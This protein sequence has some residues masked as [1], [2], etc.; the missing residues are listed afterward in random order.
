MDE[1]HAGLDQDV[2]L[3][4]E[5]GD[6]QV[7]I[8]ARNARGSY[9]VPENQVDTVADLLDPRKIWHV[10]DPTTDNKN[11]MCASGIEK[12]RCHHVF[13][14]EDIRKVRAHWISI[15]NP[16]HHW[17][18]Y[19]QDS[20]T[21]ERSPPNAQKVPLYSVAGFPWRETPIEQQ[22]LHYFLPQGNGRQRVCRRFFEKG[23]GISHYVGNAIAAGTKSQDYVRPLRHKLPSYQHKP[24]Q[25]AECISF[26]EIFFGDYAQT[27]GDGHRYFPVS[28]SF[29]Y[30]YFNSFWPWW[31]ETHGE[32]EDKAPAMVPEADQELFEATQVVKP[33]AMHSPEEFRNYYLGSEEKVEEEI[34]DDN[35]PLSARNRRYHPCLSMSPPLAPMSPPQSRRGSSSSPG[36]LPPS[37]FRLPLPPGSPEDSLDSDEKEFD[38]W[39]ADQSESDAEDEAADTRAAMRDLKILQKEKGFPSFSTFLRAR[40]NAR[41]DNVKKRAKHFHCKCNTCDTLQVLLYRALKNH[42]DRSEY[43]KQRK[44]H[45]YEVKHWREKEVE[46]HRKAKTIPGQVTVLS[47][48]DTKSMGFPRTTNRH[49][50]G[51]P[52]DKIHLIPWNCTNHGTGENIYVYDMKGK[53][54][55]GANRLITMLYHVIRRIKLKASCTDIEKAQKTCLKLVLMADN[56]PENKNNTFFCFCQDLIERGWYDEIELL[57]GPVGHTHNGNDAVHWVH[58]QLVGNHVSITPAEFF[59][60]YK[61]AWRDERT[62]PTPIILDCQ[63]NF[64]EYYLRYRNTIGGFTNSNVKNSLYVRAFR[65]F[66]NVENMVEMVIKGSPSNPTWYGVNSVAG[67]PGF[68]MLKSCPEGSPFLVP[69]KKRTVNPKYV[70]RLRSQ[71]VADYCRYN[72]RLPMHAVLI[73]MGEKIMVPSEGRLSQAEWTELP[74]YRQKNLVGYTTIEKIGLKETGYWYVVPF[75]RPN[76]EIMKNFWNLPGVVEHVPPAVLSL[77][78]FVDTKCP[79]VS[80]TGSKSNRAQKRPAPDKK[81]KSRGKRSLEGGNKKPRK[82]AKRGKRKGASDSDEEEEWVDDAEEEAE[83]EEEEAATQLRMEAEEDSEKEEKEDSEKT[84]DERPEGLDPRIPTSWDT[85]RSDAQVGKFAVVEAEWE[86]DEIQGAGQD[87]KGIAVFRVFLSCFF[88]VFLGVLSKQDTNADI[89]R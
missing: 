51:L 13:S 68:R 22:R 55:K 50:K 44:A 78:P 19:L 76:P 71:K 67:A 47:Y 60:N 72:G 46:L 37:T 11:C 74:P 5:L 48:D 69:Q 54:R 6:G 16:V 57:Y 36:S 14:F 81:D 30:L 89:F 8:H 86:H 43:E 82:H 45:Y 66:R 87:M 38:E 84:E 9:D 7:R 79:K 34:E 39:N 20:N 61:H 77:P 21:A 56:A 52:E 18:R 4:E 58:N 41:F 10:L 3:R 59:Q 26:W 27:S 12:P 49:P 73:E 1:K 32:K 29:Y 53:W 63:F 65:F 80:Y 64:D 42:T 28:V 35:E 17:V 62:R 88:F 40:Y 24:A 83:D 2:W 25:L 70:N 85:P 75:I 23:L 15:P 31:L 33:V